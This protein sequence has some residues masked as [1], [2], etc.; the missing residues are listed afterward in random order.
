M[1]YVL[2]GCI[3]GDASAAL[4]IIHRRGLGKTRHIDTSYLWVQQVAAQRRLAYSKVLGKDNP[5]DLYTKHVDIQT[6]DKH[7]AKLKCQYTEGRASAETKSTWSGNQTQDLREVV[8]TQ[9]SR[10]Q[11]AWFALY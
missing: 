9:K 4:G 8:G 1:G 7:V 5:A 3:L 11:R 10:D 6:M 2:K